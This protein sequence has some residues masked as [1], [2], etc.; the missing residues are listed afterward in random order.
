MPEFASPM[1]KVAAELD[2][3]YPVSPSELTLLS[4]KWPPAPGEITTD[5]ALEESEAPPTYR[6][7]KVMY[8][9]PDVCVKVI[10]LPL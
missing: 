10:P 6:L 4:K 3:K 9:P 8:W 7:E 5:V 2:A 1:V